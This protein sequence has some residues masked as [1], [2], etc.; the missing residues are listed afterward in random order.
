MSR[1]DVQVVMPSY[2]APGE[3]L[4]HGRIE[5]VVVHEVVDCK[6]SFVHFADERCSPEMP[7]S[8]WS[9]C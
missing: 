7:G 6:V 5:G 9:A 4:E 1:D 3:L 8:L 2:D